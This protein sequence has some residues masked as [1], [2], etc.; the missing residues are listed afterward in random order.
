[1]FWCDF[2]YDF[3]LIFDRF[4]ID[5]VNCWL[6]SGPSKPSKWC[7][8]RG[9][10]LIFIKS[11]SPNNY[12]K[13]YQFSI[14]N[15]PKMINFRVQKRTQTLKM[16]FSSLRNVEIAWSIFDPKL[17]NNDPKSIFWGGGFGSHFRSKIDQQSTKN[18]TNIDQKSTEKSKFKKELNNQT[19]QFSH[20][21]LNIHHRF[22]GCE[23]FIPSAFFAQPSF[24]FSFFA[25]SSL[26]LSLFKKKNSGLILH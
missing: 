13:N 26:S 2:W 15:F 7:F 17:S 10:M 23:P 4:W 1:M 3:W 24:S 8:R 25:S 19:N 5:F 14:Q 11:L 16:A 18:R 12:S 20:P 22:G 21:L 6:I 9:H